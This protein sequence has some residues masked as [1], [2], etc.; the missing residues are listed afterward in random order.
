MSIYNDIIVVCSMETHPYIL[1]PATVTQE[2][3]GFLSVLGVTSVSRTRYGTA[4]SFVASKYMNHM[5]KKVVVLTMIKF[6]L[7]NIGFFHET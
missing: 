3:H 1:L 7:N 2:S 4:C 6:Y 5:A